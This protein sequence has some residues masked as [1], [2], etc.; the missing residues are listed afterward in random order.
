MEDLAAGG[1]EGSEMSLMDM[2]KSI[3]EDTGKI[4]T[5]ENALRDLKKNLTGKIEQIANRL[6]A[7]E[8]KQTTQET[9]NLELEEKFAKLEQMIKDADARKDTN[10]PTPTESIR[11]DG[12]AIY[13]ARSS[14]TASTTAPRQNFKMPEDELVIVV[15]P[16]G[17]HKDVRKAAVESFMRTLPQSSKYFSIQPRFLHGPIC[18]LKK[19]RSAPQAVVSQCLEEATVKYEDNTTEITVTYKEVQHKFNLKL[20]KPVHP[21]KIKRNACLRSAEKH[22]LEHAKNTKGEHI[23]HLLGFRHHQS[24]HHRSVHGNFHGRKVLLQRHASVW[25]V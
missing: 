14:A 9:K 12:P 15:F 2:M 20:R 3:K 21:D 4:I 16:R 19:I 8:V 22:V 1:S 18:H 25:L 23:A 10:W 5:V 7:L 13:S 17:T 24:W 6:E 11:M